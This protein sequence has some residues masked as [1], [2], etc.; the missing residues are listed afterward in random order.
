MQGL[1]NRR[2]RRQIIIAV[3]ILIGIFAVLALIGQMTT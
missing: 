1:M 3:G 2:V